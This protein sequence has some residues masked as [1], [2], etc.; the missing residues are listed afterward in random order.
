MKKRLATTMASVL[1]AGVMCV[2]FTACGDSAE[3]MKGEEVTAEQ[4][5]AAFSAE[6]FENVKIEIECDATTTYKED[7]AWVSGGSSDK[8]EIVIADGK[9]YYKLQVSPKGGN[10]RNAEQYEIKTNGGIAVYRQNAAGSWIESEVSQYFQAFLMVDHIET[11]AAQYGIFEYNAEKKGYVMKAGNVLRTKVY[12]A[13]DGE[14]GDA[15]NPMPDMPEEGGC[16]PDV[17]NA[18]NGS[19][20]SELINGY[21]DWSHMTYKFKDGKLVAI[22][23]EVDMNME[24]LGGEE[25]QIK[26]SYSYRFTYGGQSVTLPEINQ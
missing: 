5:A 2:G 25:G 11:L 13:Q 7:G 6:N 1:L 19:V 17:P 20:E 9:A 3:S 14:L 22:W 4:W 23:A 10:G 16:E 21:R 15:E 24:D 26:A 12:D 8:A 18:P